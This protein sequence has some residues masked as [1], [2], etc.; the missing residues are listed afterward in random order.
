MLVYRLLLLSG[1][2]ETDASSSLL[3]FLATLGVGR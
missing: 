3:G 2:A 1:G